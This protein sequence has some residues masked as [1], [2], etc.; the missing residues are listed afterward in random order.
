M[1]KENKGMTFLQLYQL[2]AAMVF[3]IIL[4]IIKL[5]FP[6]YMNS[7]KEDY[8]KF[9]ALSNDFYNKAIATEVPKLEGKI[10][11]QFNRLL[12]IKVKQVFLIRED[13]VLP[14]KLSFMCP[15]PE[16]TISDSYGFRADPLT[17]DRSFHSGVDYSAPLGTEV[18]SAAGGVVSAVGYNENY[19]KF[20]TIKHSFDTYTLY[21]HLDSVSAFCGQFINAG[22]VIG[23]VGSTGRS[24]GF[25]LHFEI[26]RGKYRLNPELCYTNVP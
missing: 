20:V 21:A 15:I 3:A 8:R 17:G 5:L 2:K 7:I 26:I 18:S 13:K 11:S 14:E 22:K 4:I 19:G 25:H 12:N 23:R 1:A 6:S 9:G 16:P 10:K 24:T